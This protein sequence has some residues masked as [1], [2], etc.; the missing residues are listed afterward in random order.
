MTDPSSDLRA[1]VL[2]EARAH[3]S[4]TRSALVKQRAVA[5]MIGLVWICGFASF[6]RVRP[7]AA[8]VVVLAVWIAG[9]LVA[10]GY[11]LFTPKS[12]LGRPRLA[13]ALLG[14]LVGAV[15]LSA[16][17]V[18]A[19]ILGG[20]SDAHHTGAGLCWL[21]SMGIAVVPLA[22]GLWVERRS[23]PI[24]PGASGAAIGAIA[25]AWGG[26]AMSFVCGRSE[27]A[28]VLA[29]HVLSLLAVVVLASVVGKR[30]LMLR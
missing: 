23:D 27:P 15:V 9:A 29:G 10:S 6:G 24:A 16:A 7:D 3:P 8:G 19:P 18:A 20:H 14:P 12:S 4:P 5:A 1:R 13:L 17:Y 22:L 2:D 11:A 28:H 26:V 30:V 25:G 21:L